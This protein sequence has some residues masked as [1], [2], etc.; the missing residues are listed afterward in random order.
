[1]R[2]LYQTKLKNSIQKNWIFEQIVDGLGG[3][4]VNM[5]TNHSPLLHLSLSLNFLFSLHYRNLIKA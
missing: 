4:G 1:M 2:F 5:Q 3:L